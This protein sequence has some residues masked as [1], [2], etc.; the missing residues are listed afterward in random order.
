MNNVAFQKP[1]H[2]STRKELAQYITDEKC[3]TFWQGD[4][5][6]AYIDI[7]LENNYYLDR[8]EVEAP[9][10]QDLCFCL[11]TSMNG[12]DFDKAETSLN[13]KEARIIRIHIEYS[14]LAKPVVNQ[15]RVWGTESKTDILERPEI[16]ITSYEDTKH[17][18]EITS[19]EIYDEVLGIIGRRVG[20]EYQS[21]FELELAENPI[22][23][24]TYDYY[25]LTDRNGKIH[26][27]ANN[28]VS[29]ASGIHYY[30]KYFCKVHISQVGDQVKMPECV[31]PV[32]KVL[33]RETKARIRYAYNYCTFSYSMAFYGRNE[34]RDEL[35]WLALNGVNLVLDITGQEEVWRRFLKGLG[36]SHED[37]K[38]FIAGPAYYAWAYMANL[39]GFGGPVHD[40]WFEERTELAR[41]NH[42]IMRTLGMQPVL[43]GYSGMVPN[44]IHEYDSDAEII[45]QGTWNDFQRPAMLRTTSD[46]FKT[47][48]QKFYQTQNELYCDVS[49][50]YATDPFHEGGN[51]GGMSEREI[52]STVLNSMLQADEDAVWVIQSWQGNPTSELLAGVEEVPKGKEHALIL[53]LYAEKLPHYGEGSA[54]SKAYGYKPEF[55]DAPWVFC[56]LNNFGGRLGLHGHLDNLATNIPKAFNQ[57]SCIAGI[58]IAPEAS[59]NN[60]VL[61]DFLFETI[62]QENAELPMTEIPLKEWISNYAQ[63]RYGNSSVGAEKAWQILLETVYKAE[64]NQL[65]QGAPECIAIARPA[66]K[67]R[68]ASAW[69]NTVVSYD[70]KLLEQAKEFMMED[71]ELLKGSAGYLY[72]VIT[73]QQ[74]VLSNK[75]LECYQ[76]MIKALENQQAEAFDECAEQFLELIDEMEQ[77]TAS[78]EHYR[79]DR[80]I[81]QVERLAE[82]ADDYSR[83][84]YVW[85]AKMLITTWGSYEQSEKGKLHDYSNR[86]WSGLIKE[87]YKPRWERWIEERRKELKGEK[88]DDSITW[89]EWEWNWT[90]S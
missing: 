55:N 14:S 29:L 42:R 84:M 48:A 70:M 30:L 90:R 13:G 25:E 23:G 2:V 27:K 8:V 26:V 72:D 18:D 34:W 88:N 47:Y 49:H 77:V 35:D 65:G 63:R 71:Y 67:I 28:G 44:D 66:Q 89:F 22:E 73:I 4:Y 39:S 37:T 57:C 10:N 17:Y 56:M 79:L 58:G 15:V 60:P 85:N 16:N 38:D 19:Q 80:W 87:F 32:S 50:Y 46:S 83:K 33:F 24:H 43:Q 82:H 64:L 41:E 59:A 3:K 76:E 40:S 69:G 20:R 81:K 86:Q 6:P 74:Q 52:A 62:W 9:E 12:R 54:E 45:E 78:N 21:W 1:V 5:Y 75:S 36:Y 11:Y 53:D 61:Y 31:I 68:A 7:D 51:T